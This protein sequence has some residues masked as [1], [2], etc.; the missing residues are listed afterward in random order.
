MAEILPIDFENPEASARS[1]E[2]IQSVLNSGGV[3]AF[4]TDTFYGLGADPFNPESIAKIF[5]IKQRPADKPLLVLIHSLDQ[6]NSL[7]DKTTPPQKLLMNQFWPGPLT[8]IFKAAPDISKALTGGTGNLGVRLPAH[9]F[10][11]QLLRALNCPLTAPSANLSGTGELRTAEEVASALGDQLDLIVDG[12]PTAGGK[13][14]T[15]LDTTTN[16]PTLLREGALS[17]GDLELV[18]PVQ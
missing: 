2:N 16:P 17:R 1:I 4:P 15:V 8:L 18:T 9:L 6:L 3:I 12:G 11:L 10:T 13:S 7:T 5:R 14:S